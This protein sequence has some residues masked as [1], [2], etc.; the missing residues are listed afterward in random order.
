MQNFP[1][2]DESMKSRDDGDDVAGDLP[3]EGV[4]GPSDL[5]LVRRAQR[6]E[7]GAFDLLVLKYQHKV[8]KLVARLLRD[9]TEAEDVAQE[10]FVKAYRALGSFRGD[11][12]F[13]T[14]LYRIA[15][16]TAR[17]AIASRQR[18]PLD[19]EAELSE[20]EQLNLASRLRDTDT[21]E[22]TALSEEIRVT[23]NQAIELLP[24]DLRTAIV[25]REVE[26]LSYEEIAA[27]MD[28]PVG[29][30]RSRIFRAREAVDRALKPLLD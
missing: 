6:N 10:A 5:E 25:L 30:V 4:A 1:P 28:C 11:S 24:E 14:W 17:N 15:V 26:G 16:N 18:R 9:P 3:D 12:A 2:P 29:T 8:V 21:P 19:Y 7:R 13:Y 20:G 23:V 27:A 22:A